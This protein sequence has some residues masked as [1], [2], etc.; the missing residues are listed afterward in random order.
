MSGKKMA[1][2]GGIG[3]IIVVVIAALMGADPS[4]LLQMIGAGAGQS[5]VQQQNPAITAEQEE[6]KGFV[7]VVLADT[8]DV[9]AQVVPGG[10]GEVPRTR[11]WCS[12]LDR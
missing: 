12:S 10:G 6:L 2:G 3:T 11:T 9:L 5:A 4:A 8:E 1:L 7:S